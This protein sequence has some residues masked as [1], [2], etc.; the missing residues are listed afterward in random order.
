MLQ[1][2]I[3]YFEQIFIQILIIPDWFDWLIYFQS[4]N[5][6]TWNV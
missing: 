2:T 5:K 1:I 3:K 4:I 6:S